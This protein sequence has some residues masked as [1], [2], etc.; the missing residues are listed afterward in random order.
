M[1]PNA[2]P[3]Y[4]DQFDFDN[5][6]GRYAQALFCKMNGTWYSTQQAGECSSGTVGAEDAGEGQQP[7]RDRR[8]G[9]TG[10]ED[11]WWNATAQKSVN[12]SCVTDRVIAAVL[13]PER[14]CVGCSKA[15]QADVTSSCW[16]RCFF[17]RLLAMQRADILQVFV[18]AFEEEDAGGC[19]AVPPLPP[20]PPPVKLDDSAT[21]RSPATVRFADRSTRVC[22]AV[23]LDGCT[24]PVQAAL[25]RGSG[26]SPD[27]SLRCGG[28]L[29]DLR[30]PYLV[31]S[32]VP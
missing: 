17:D 19:P 1:P 3:Q 31:C 16:L 10:G 6:W 22:C 9:N 18:A 8:A 7:E 23:S 12:A 27:V 30:R 32:N 28:V 29:V 21:S 2:R 26:R 13:T 11:C 5:A 25:D 15:E 14:G 20:L 4:R 24:P